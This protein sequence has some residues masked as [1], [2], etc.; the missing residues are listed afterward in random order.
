[1]LTDS[2]RSNCQ[3][4]IV[5]VSCS[6]PTCKDATVSVPSN[7][8][9]NKECDYN[10]DGVADYSTT[11]VNKACAVV[12]AKAAAQAGCTVHTIAVGNQCDTALMKAIAHVGCGKAQ[13]VPQNTDPVVMNNN[14]QTCFQKVSTCTPTCKTK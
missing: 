14:V 12:Q 7:W 5:V 3:K 11:D 6:T 10:H 8:D 9:W 2:G 13:T 4:T 1:M